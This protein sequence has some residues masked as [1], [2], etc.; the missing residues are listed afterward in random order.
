MI[1]TVFSTNIGKTASFNVFPNIIKDDFTNVKILGVLSYDTAMGFNLAEM[2]EKVYPTLPEGT[3]NDYTAYNYLLVRFPNG[4]T[5]AIGLP[6]IEEASVRIYSTMDIVVRIRNKGVED[7]DTL[8]MILAAN[9]YQDVTIST[10][11]K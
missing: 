8:R 2:H 5:S 10:Q 11:A 9:G 6:W 1:D 7:I 3:P 4:K